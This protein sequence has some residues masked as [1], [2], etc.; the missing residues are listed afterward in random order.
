MPRDWKLNLSGGCA[1]F[2]GRFSSFCFELV[3]NAQWW[4]EWQVRG[5]PSSHL[6]SLDLA[7]TSGSRIQY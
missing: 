3:R 4:F 5:W 7:S 1:F 6:D 2:Q